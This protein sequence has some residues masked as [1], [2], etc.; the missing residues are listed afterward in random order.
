MRQFKIYVIK[1]A[2]AVRMLAEDDYEAFK[3][4]LETDD[5]LLFG[6]PITFEAESECRAFA[7]ALALT[8]N[9]EWPN[10]WL[11]TDSNLGD[12]PYIELIENYQP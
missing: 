4:L 2:E 11:L 8:E 12:L 6:E 10:S 1:D 5:T 7:N 3:S 9:E